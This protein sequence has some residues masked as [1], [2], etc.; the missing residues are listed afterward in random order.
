MAIPAMYGYASVIFQHAA[1]AGDMTS[2]AKLGW[3]RLR[4]TGLVLTFMQNAHNLHLL[5]CTHGSL[6]VFSD[7]SNMFHAAVADALRNWP[8]AR[9]RVGAIEVARVVTRS[10]HVFIS[11]LGLCRLIFLSRMASDIAVAIA[12]HPEAIQVKKNHSCILKL[13]TIIHCQES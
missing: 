13:A 3:T 8:S 5:S 12:A 9:C 2:L 10:R 4:P 7:P 1:Y 6:S 11:P